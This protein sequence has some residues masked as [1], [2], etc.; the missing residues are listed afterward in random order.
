[1]TGSPVVQVLRHAFGHFRALYVA[2]ALSIVS[3]IAELLAMTSLFPLAEM[4][5][6]RN[7]AGNSAWARVSALLPD[8]APIKVF[9]LFFLALLFFRV[10]TAGLTGLISASLHRKLIAHFSANAFEAFI[11]HLTF[12]DIQSRSIG[13]FIT[14]AGDEA[15]RASQIVIA[16]IRLVPTLLLALLYFV[17]LFVQAL[18]VG[19]AVL[20]FL[21]VMGLGMVGAFRRTHDLGVRQQ[22]ESRVLN[23]F[24]VDAMNGLRTV[25]A[26]GAEAY[27]GARYRDMI[28]Q[29]AYTCFSVDA[30]N[31]LGRALPA[32]CLVLAAGVSVVV[33]MD[34]TILASRL[35]FAMAAT[36]IVLRFLP[37]VGQALDTFFRLTADLR[38]GQNIAEVVAIADAAEALVQ[39]PEQGDGRRIRRIEF[40]S[41]DFAY[42]GVTPVLQN[43]SA[44]FKAGRTYAVAGPSGSG[45][46]TLMD[47]LLGFYAPTSG[48]IVVNGDVMNSKTLE[49]LRSKVAIV[50]Q[51]PRLFNDTV[52]SNLSFGKYV[53]TAD[54]NG[55][56]IAAELADVII[57][58]QGGL[59]APVTYQGSNL[60]GGQRQRITIARALLKNADVL[61]LDEST[62]GL[63]ADTRD[64]VVSNLRSLFRDR[65]LIFLTHDKDL[66][67][68]VDEVIALENPAG[69]R[70]PDLKT[71]PGMAL[72]AAKI[73]Q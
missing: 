22:A 31:I 38:A 23:S 8:Q 15:N 25:R 70:A 10:F 52:R 69:G 18:W 37:L 55:A 29:Y 59:D 13:H 72:E 44:L 11:R 9:L 64:K 48:H 5:M 58:L 17:A 66:L 27:A 1:V 47:L 12:S 68:R 62:T 67:S 36:V 63:D 42:D 32:I 30:V 7:I 28:N 50:E 51:Q 60:S 43:F 34:E 24:F 54:V 56:L 71:P 3:V 33:W 20:A 21:I 39:E 65:V 16:A 41:V 26:F 53:T 46:S 49:A 61:I 73:V 14:L 2:V 35:A 45:K 4:A 57:G 19:F 6:G 40:R